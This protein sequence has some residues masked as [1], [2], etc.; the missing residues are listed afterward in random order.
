M[1]SKYEDKYYKMEVNN[2]WFKARRDLITAYAM[3]LHSNKILDIGCGAGG[4]LETLRARGF[5]KLCGIDISKK[6]IQICEK[7]SLKVFNMPADKMSFKNSSFDTIIAADILEHTSDD[8]KTLSEWR[9]VLLPGGHLILFVPAFMHLW[10]KHDTLSHHRKRYRLPEL[11]DCCKKNGFRVLKST[12]WNFT[13]YSPRAVS[14]QIARTFN[15]GAM[16][17]PDVPKLINEALYLMLKVEN[18]AILKGGS[19]PVGIS[20]FAVLRKE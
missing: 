13:L 15:S 1:E 18:S 10:S 20:C 17:F 6:A 12:Y 4:T 7:K 8:N 11:I 5:S 19:F 3:R 14:T 9:R 16:H 2:W